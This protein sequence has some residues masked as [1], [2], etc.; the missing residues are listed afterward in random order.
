MIV[1]QGFDLSTG[2]DE[3]LVVD[4]V[5]VGVVD[6]GDVFREPDLGAEEVEGVD[7]GA[8]GLVVPFDKHLH[9]YFLGFCYV[10]QRF[11]QPLVV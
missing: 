5:D 1:G 8:V 9:F 4:V 6:E 10:I 11:N 2:P 3:S 7:E